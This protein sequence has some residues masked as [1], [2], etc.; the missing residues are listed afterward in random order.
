[1]RFNI[2]ISFFIIMVFVFAAAVYLGYF[3]PDPQT[4]RTS[5]FDKSLNSGNQQSTHAFDFSRILF[6]SPKSDSPAVALSVGT[7]IIYDIV[8][9]RITQ[10]TVAVS[11]SGWIAIP[12]RLCVGGYS[13]YFYSAGGEAL[14][15]FGG[16]FG[17]R[18]D[19]GIWQ[20]KNTNQISGPPVF[21]AKPD[22][23]LT[24]VSI[25]SEKSAELTDLSIL[26]EQQNFY[27]IF[28]ADSMDEPGLFIQDQKIVGWSFGDLA[29]GGYLWK[30]PD[31]KNL[32]YELSV[33]DF[34]RLTFESSRE[35]QFIIA[36]SQKD[37]S[38][39]NQLET[40][41]NGFRSD[42]MLFD[43]NTPLH[44]K[45]KAVIAKMRS[46]ISQMIDKG[47]FY[48]IVSIFDGK[49]LSAAG[50]VSLLIDVL[51]FSDQV[52]GPEH[53][54]DIIEE[55]LGD[56]EGF[57][58][59]QVYQI[60]QFQKELYRKWLT[61]LTNDK[62]YSR[63]IE[64]YQQAANFFIDDPEIHLL[65][66]KLA[67]VFDDWKTAQEILYSHK[68]PIDLTD[69]VRTLGGQ[70]KELKFQGNKIVVRF[71]PGSGRI[72]VTGV[73][74][75]RLNQ[76]FVID[77][78][79]SMVTIPTAA[80][81]KLGI[82]INDSTPI[83]ELITAGGVI[84][85]PQIILHSIQLDGWTEYNITAYVIDMPDQSGFGLLGLNYLNR[86]RMDLNAKSGVLTLAPR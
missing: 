6:S 17:D 81:K 70:I 49:V 62:D 53:S 9:N 19:I 32:V 80:V 55:V 10:L 51:T 64:V 57:N 77:T 69:Q 82:E 11:E 41:A 38:L 61:L 23:P 36:Y 24:W 46:I 29:G 71:F 47:N 50:D 7:V 84:E 42:P 85:A 14:E 43:D 73:L 65:G 34:Y 52:N 58:E 39:V 1:M 79:A 78:G 30:G 12:A 16:I 2:L 83:R 68:F 5:D 26:S 54:I 31:E 22:S 48:G 74:N 45:S 20:L 25:V 40:F 15:I 3:K 67:L 37:I 56:P 63:G 4:V 66:V 86:F 28:L 72:P 27:H 76:N 75:N 8:G 33:Y 35:E 13:W 18:D 21:P 44:L 59:G 60:R